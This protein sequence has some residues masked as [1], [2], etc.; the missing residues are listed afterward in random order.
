[1]FL[2]AVSI[3]NK[4]KS[5]TCLSVIQYIMSRKDIN[6][7]FISTQTDTA[8]YCIGSGFEHVC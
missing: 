8:A 4:D 7:F 3:G 1:M 6:Y 2:H 5:K